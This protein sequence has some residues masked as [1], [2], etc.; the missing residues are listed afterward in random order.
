M[1]A[2]IISVGTEL[3]LG[4]IVDTNSV[5]ISQ[6]LAAA[7]VNLFRKQ[8]VGDNQQ[9]AAQAIREALTRADLVVTT[10][11]LGPTVDDV[12]RAAIAD[13]TGRPLYRDVAQEAVVRA[14][15]ARWGREPSENNLRQ[16]EL[17]QGGQALSNPVGTAPGLLLELEGGKRVVAVPGVPREM[18]RMIHDH[19]LPLLKARVGDAVIRVRLLKTAAL[20]ESILDEKIAD[21]E[22]SA[23]PTVGLAAHTG[24]VDIRLTARAATEREATLLLDHMAKQLY[25]RVGRWIYGEDEQ[26]LESVV[27]TE[28][29]EAKETLLLREAHVTSGYAARLQQAGAALLAHEVAQPAPLPHAEDALS[30]LDGWRNERGAAWAMG[31]FSTAGGGAYSDRPGETMVALVGPSQRFTKHYAQSGS[32][33]ISREWLWARALMMLRGALAARQ[34]GTD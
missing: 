26:T 16:A 1:N 18:K 15:F 33:E 7:G 27:V 11:G 9:R 24:R 32:D 6:Q 13:A 29:R 28:L 4:Q 23:N 25:K 8:T 22:M 3:L 2:E 31:F 34:R 20:G 12:T 5:W 19:L 17:P 14:I 21:L 10:G 30:Q